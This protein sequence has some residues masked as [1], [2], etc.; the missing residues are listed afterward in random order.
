M[1]TDRAGDSGTRRQSLL[2]VSEVFHSVQGEGTLIGAPSTF[3]RLTGCNY[4][5]SWCDT[6][7]TWKPGQIRPPDWRSVAELAANAPYRHVVITGGEPLL[8]DLG[9]LLT[10]LADHHVTIETNASRK[11]SYPQVDL[12][13]LSP[14]LGS[15]GHQP[16]PDVIRHYVEGFSDRC[17]LKFVIGCDDDLTEVKTLLASLPATRQVPVVLQPVTPPQL[18]RSEYLD[19]FGD[20]VLAIAADPFWRDYRLQLLPQLHR[21]CW[22]NKEGI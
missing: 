9:E 3:I 1:T 22:P 15:S 8:H 5:C 7:Y 18:D 12:W 19:S 16:D 20:W 17:Q 4:H 6:P 11:A 2:P 21:L 14:K 10:A 13:S